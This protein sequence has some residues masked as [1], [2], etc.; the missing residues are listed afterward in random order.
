MIVDF[1]FSSCFHSEQTELDLRLLLVS[2]PESTN[3]S[4]HIEMFTKER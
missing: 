3:G 1:S 2:N 4:K